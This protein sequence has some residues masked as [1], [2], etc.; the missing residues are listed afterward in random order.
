MVGPVGVTEPVGIAGL[1]GHAP[2]D[3][4]LVAMKATEPALL[5]SEH[6]FAP[7]MTSV[8]SSQVL[9]S[10][11]SSEPLQV[12]PAAT[13]QPQPVQPRVSVK[14]SYRTRLSATQQGKPGRRR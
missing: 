7:K 12:A 1:G 13:P 14:P 2:P 8:R 10:Y 11:T 4:G 5:F 3:G 6:A 9:P